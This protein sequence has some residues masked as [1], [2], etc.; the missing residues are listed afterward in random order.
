[1]TV[2]VEHPTKTVS[3]IT[4]SLYKSTSG[5]L[6]GLR[7]ELVEGELVVSFREHKIPEMRE[8]RCRVTIV[9][10]HI[11]SGPASNSTSVTTPGAGTAVL[12]R[13][14]GTHHKIKTVVKG[15]ANANTTI[16]RVLPLVSPS[17]AMPLNTAQASNRS[18]ILRTIAGEL[19]RL[20]QSLG[21]ECAF[22][23]S[24]ACKL[25]GSARLPEVSTP[26]HVGITAVY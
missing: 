16:P 23:G 15:Q 10:G 18:D 13:L 17:P 5:K 7:F 6:G 8:H 19:V 1:M 25:Y 12:T 21:F 2:L 4:D 22:F 26:R 11:A 14:T 9:S 3:A 24:M 20:V